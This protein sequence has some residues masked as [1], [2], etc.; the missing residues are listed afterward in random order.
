MSVGLSAEKKRLRALLRA[1]RRGLT[2]DQVAEKSRRIVERLC[3]FF[4]FQNAGIIVNYASDT[5]EVQ[6]EA[7]WQTA[8]A[9]HKAVYYPRISA[10][11]AR[12]DFVRRS[13][14]ERLVVGLFGIRTP[15]GNERLTAGQDR[16]AVVLTPGIGFDPQG[17]R[18]GRGR[19]YYDRAFRHVLAGAARVALA[20][21]FQ[22]LRCV[23][24]GPRDEPVNWII[25][26]SRLLDCRAN[27]RRNRLD[28]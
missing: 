6:T 17:C 10:D 12:L 4:L 27:A 7:A 24:S 16:D 28:R 18:L 19:G 23:P 3:A 22:V 2:P 9:Q 26:E 20:Y 13:P 1:Q 25:T 5:S 15:P 14:S 21:D 8:L 11:R